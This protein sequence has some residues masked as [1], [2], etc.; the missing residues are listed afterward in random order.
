MPLQ[1]LDMALCQFCTRVKAQQVFFISQGA[2]VK[3]Y[4]YQDFSVTPLSEGILDMLNFFC[5]NRINC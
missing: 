5:L 3:K 4:L 2:V 1:C